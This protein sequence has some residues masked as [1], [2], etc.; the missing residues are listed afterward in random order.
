[1][2]DK[3]FYDRI[4]EDKGVFDKV[5]YDLELM[6]KDAPNPVC[7]PKQNLQKLILFKFKQSV[8]QLKNTMIVLDRTN[9]LSYNYYRTK[10]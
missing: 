2:T 7:E 10:H 4:I 3:T 5:V 8:K 6:I 9:V 1:M